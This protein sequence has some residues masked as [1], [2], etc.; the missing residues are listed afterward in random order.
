MGAGFGAGVF[1]KDLA[2]EVDDGDVVAG[3]VA[4]GDNENLLEGV[5][6]VDLVLHPVQADGAPYHVLMP[7]SSGRRR[8]LVPLVIILAVAELLIGIGTN[9]ASSA[10]PEDWQ[11][12]GSP[13]V[14]WP[15][16]AV[17]FV[18][19]LVASV[20]IARREASSPEPAEQ[21]ATPSLV[22]ALPNR[23]PEWIS[24]R[25]SSRQLRA[26]GRRSKR[27]P[28]LTVLVGESGIGKSHLAAEYARDRYMAGWLVV[29]IDASSEASTA[30]ELST[31]A[32]SLGLTKKQEE[33][34]GAGL[35]RDHLQ[36]RTESALLVFDG[37]VDRGSFERW[38]PAAGPNHTIVTSTFSGL[39]ALGRAIDVQRFTERQSARYLKARL[40][41]ASKADRRALTRTIG[42][43]PS[44]LWSAT[45]V[46]RSERLQISE[47]IARYRSAPLA[48]VLRD[49]SNSHA[50]PPSGALGAVNQ[51]LQSFREHSASHLNLLPPEDVLA[52]A[53]L[54]APVEIA[55]YLLDPSNA[56]D[57][58]RVLAS[59]TDW[60]LAVWQLDDRSVIIH[61][62]PAR[63]TREGMNR[64]DMERVSERFV[65]LV[66]RAWP[67]SV[68][69]DNDIA[70]TIE[71]L[72]RAT[73][74]YWR[75]AGPR[76][77]HVPARSRLLEL[78]LRSARWAFTQGVYRT[79]QVIADSVRLAT[80]PFQ[81]ERSST[82]HLAALDLSAH[83]L[84]AS[85]EKKQAIVLY[86]INLDRHI[87]SMGTSASETLRAKVALGNALRSNG[88]TTEAI[89]MFHSALAEE[90]SPDIRSE[91]EGSLGFALLRDGQL[92]AATDMLR[93]VVTERRARLG[94]DA[95][96]TL[97]ALNNL[98]H[99]LLG[100]ADEAALPLLEEAFKTKSGILGQ[101]HPQ[102]LISEH[103]LGVAEI[104]LGD[105]DKG[106]AL[107]RDTYERRVT[108]LG[109]EHPDTLATRAQL[110]DADRADDSRYPRWPVAQT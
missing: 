67:E 41:G 79:S 42:Q 6:Y 61:D 13:Q 16:L 84:L 14:V 91:A 20:V 75:N 21:R 58:D 31:A 36:S 8:S 92:G 98:G 83:A 47:Y 96:A 49:T 37:A 107:L 4:V 45:G 80:E 69:T 88:E 17:I 93:E 25:C 1:G 44:A 24:T 54:I 22:G 74:S 5:A 70:A 48:A 109:E 100:M 62:L 2:V 106:K 78:R 108:A 3:L 103:Y 15:T 56:G 97:I 99:G 82:L 90:L 33:R 32:R 110:V 50:A 53:S 29:W 76:L 46:I 7:R 71:Y 19:A 27:S 40:P 35:L 26:E 87:A 38:I 85:G 101:D 64:E 9:L 30:L 11:W 86:R 81:E 23:P 60:S 12:T 39:S 59:L 73:E 57:G 89:P 63:F 28:R 102:T 66:E 10:I 94:D 72:I 68:G 105:V 104:A 43:L 55:S 65:E 18:V 95:L 51:S 34:S 77:Q 52:V